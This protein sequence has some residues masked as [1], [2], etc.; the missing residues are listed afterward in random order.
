MNGIRLKRWQFGPVAPNVKCWNTGNEEAAHTRHSDDAPELYT[1][2]HTDTPEGAADEDAQSMSKSMTIHTL[3]QERAG[4]RTHPAPRGWNRNRMK[5]LR[6]T[7]KRSAGRRKEL[8]KH[9][10]PSNCSYLSNASTTNI[11]L[12]CHLYPKI[13]KS[14]QL[15]MWSFIVI[16]FGWRSWFG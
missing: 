6:R 5:N 14:N 9:I 2:T 8:M 1:P 16:P 4:S 12:L 10:A 15:I 7:I 11:V 3:T 13:C